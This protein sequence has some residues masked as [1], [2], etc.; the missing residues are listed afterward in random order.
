MREKAEAMVM[1]SFAADSLALGAHWIYDAG[2]IQKDYGRVDSFL[3]PSPN[4]FHSTK[5]KGDFTHYGD[6]SCVLLESI[7]ARGE[8]DRNDFSGRWRAL[9]DG[10][11]GYFDQ[12]T[13][14]TLSNYAT[15]SPVESAGSP[16]N[17]LAGASRMAPLIFCDREDPERLVKDAREQTSMTHKDPLT[18][19]SAEI[20][21]LTA[22]R[23]LKGESPVKAMTAIV[24]ERFADSV[25]AGWVA[26]GVRSKDGDSISVIGR[27]GQSCHTNEAFPGVVHLIAKYENNLEEALVQAVMAGGDSAAR[28]MM[29]GMVLGA[30]LGS[31]GIPDRW[32]S[33]M[34]RAK[35]IQALLD[36]IP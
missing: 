16:S 1:A 33:D 6:Q 8:F 12:A 10:Y 31:G 28:G 26:D 25:L 5:E 19:D 18:N 24:E 7:A 34:T 2:R 4:S 32:M 9:F 15:G 21:A 27:F 13:R 17:D 36:R 30:Y 35:Q 23:A 22:Q 14:T 29:V 11:N 20:F 3:K